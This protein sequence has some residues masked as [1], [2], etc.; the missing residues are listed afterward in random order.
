MHTSTER[1]RARLMDRLPIHPI[2]TIPTA[3][4]LLEP[5][6]PTA[7][8]PVQLLES[9]GVLTETSDKQ[10][11]RTFAYARYLE[12]LRVGTVVENRTETS[13]S[14]PSRNRPAIATRGR[15]KTR[16]DPLIS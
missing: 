2:V 5:T 1:Y 13:Q 9:L 4:N 15:K 7:G 3:V 8:K 6:K 11:D 12:K 16:S 10:H 14:A